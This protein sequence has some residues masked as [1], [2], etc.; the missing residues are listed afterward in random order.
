MKNKII[1]SK[2]KGFLRFLF[3]LFGL[4]LLICLLYYCSLYYTGDLQ[5]SNR[6]RTSA[7]L[8]PY[9]APFLVLINSNGL[10]IQPILEIFDKNAIWVKDSKLY[11]RSSP[12][13]KITGFFSEILNTKNTYVYTRHSLHKFKLSKIESVYID[14]CKEA[15]F[16]HFTIKTDAI[17]FKLK[18]PIEGYGPYFIPTKYLKSS[19]DEI[20]TKLTEMLKE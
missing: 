5:P 4:F 11:F 17:Y 16:L 8:F 12:S 9:V 10:L 13:A 2:T 3:T 15:V 7:K 20:I 1:I 19:P 14:K 18:E 6:D